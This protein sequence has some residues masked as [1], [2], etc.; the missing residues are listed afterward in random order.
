MCSFKSWIFG[1][2]FNFIKKYVFMYLVC[3]VLISLRFVKVVLLVVNKLLINIIF[4]FLIFLKVLEWIFM[5]L[6]LYFKL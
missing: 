1:N 6:F 3:R 5:L 4:I 2:F